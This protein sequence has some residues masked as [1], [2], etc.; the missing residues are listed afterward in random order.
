MTISNTTISSNY[1]HSKQQLLLQHLWLILL[2]KLIVKCIG[3][4]VSGNSWS[5]KGGGH[6]IG[7][8][9]SASHITLFF[10]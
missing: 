4:Y 10:S 7:S 5:G 3:K 8:A 1:K 9:P 2:E 6:R